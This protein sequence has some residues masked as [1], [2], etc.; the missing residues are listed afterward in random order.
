MRKWAWVLYNH[1]NLMSQ[2]R[3]TLSSWIAGTLEWQLAPAHL[4]TRANLRIAHERQQE[5]ALW[6]EGMEVAGNATMITIQNRGVDAMAAST[7]G[8]V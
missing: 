5:K 4:A 7:A 3:R 1:A 2:Q 8:E 6:E